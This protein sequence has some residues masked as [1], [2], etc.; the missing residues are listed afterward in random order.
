ME[1]KYVY[2][3]QAELPQIAEVQLNNKISRVPFYG[4]I[5]RT[6]HDM[7]CLRD[8]VTSQKLKNTQIIMYRLQ[9]AEMFKNK[10]EKTLFEFSG[11]KINYKPLS[12]FAIVI[13]PSAEYLVSNVES[14]TEKLLKIKDL[15]D[16]I[17]GVLTKSGKEKEKEIKKLFA[18]DSKIINIIEWYL[19]KQFSLNSEF[20]LPPC[21]PIKG[22]NTLQY[23]LK[24]N[25]IATTI[26]QDNGW[27]K[28]VFFALDFKSFQSEIILDT[29][30]NFIRVIKPKIVSFKL[31]NA[32]DFYKTDSIIERF[33]LN[34]FIE[35]LKW[36]RHEEKALTFSIN[37]DAL[38]CHLLG[39][40][41]CGFIEP[42][43]G[44]YN[45]DLRPRPKKIDLDAETK[46][47]SFKIFGKYPDPITLEENKFEVLQKISENTGEAFP[48]HCP[49]CS[50]YSKLPTDSFIFNKIRK[51]HRVH[52]RDA[53]IT[54]LI[55]SINNRNLR[56][57]LFD[58]FSE[59]NSKLKIFKEAYA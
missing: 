7:E 51:R 22:K 38:G 13:D 40:Q 55:E 29:I 24:I 25:R 12:Q 8:V 53:F 17:K 20:S 6:N 27:E 31:F 23:A 49:E 45:P 14:E 57:S 10:I 52:I 18:D 41:L 34:N 54:E 2:V 46:S 15:P 58:R 56:I 42:I 5:I 48:C 44:N 33:N 3:E 4:V 9:D 30:L 21:I 35:A 32:N 28:A 1:T 39:Q 47:D 11:E 43:S 50:K 59:Q 19:K 26:Q 37:M 36:Y 16:S